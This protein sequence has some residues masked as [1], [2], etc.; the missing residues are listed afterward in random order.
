MA[1]PARLGSKAV[2]RSDGSM[3]STIQPT[4]MSEMGGTPTLLTTLEIEG[5]ES[6]S[7]GSWSFTAELQVDNCASSTISFSQR[8]LPGWVSVTPPNSF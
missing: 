7:L 8:T 5:L 1:Y 4:L 6:E 3:I 2:V